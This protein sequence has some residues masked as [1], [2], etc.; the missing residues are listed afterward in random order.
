M[1]GKKEG[2]KK[3]AEDEFDPQD[4]VKGMTAM[5]DAIKA[6]QAEMP[7]QIAIGV[8]QAV[9]AAMPAAKEPDPDPDPGPQVDDDD[10][11]K[12]SRAQF[13]AHITEGV[14]NAVKKDISGPLGKQVEDAK[15]DTE[16]ERLVREINQAKSDHTDFMDWGQE[17]KDLVQ[18][19][20]NLSI[21]QAYRLARSL[22]GEKSQKI[23]EVTKADLEKK[24]EEEK[25]QAADQGEENQDEAVL[26]LFP[27]SAPSSTDSKREPAKD[28]KEAAER[29][30]EDVG[31]GRFQSMMSQ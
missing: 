26:S 1:F 23:D 14:V 13:M 29:A 25:K 12:M 24:Q 31:M 30:W 9:K 3:G 27:G 11:E 28:N 10:L 18:K 2:D 8:A 15:Q 7:K 16:R 5:G 19:N 21:E 6:M 20:P 4:L 17:V 22:D